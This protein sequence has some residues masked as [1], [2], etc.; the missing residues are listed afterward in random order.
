MSPKVRKNISL[1]QII[2]NRFDD[3]VVGE[4]STRSEE[5]EELMKSAVNVHSQEEPELKKEIEELENKKEE[6]QQQKKQLTEEI[7]EIKQ[8]ISVKRQELKERDRREKSI[9][10]AVENLED[11]FKEKREKAN[12]DEEALEKL[13]SSET[14]W[15]WIDERGIENDKLREALREEYVKGVKE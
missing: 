15:F 11:K 2:L 12:S 4:N 6:K 10:E 5:I 7:K 1:N 13:C 8:E 9:R 14:Y 3:I